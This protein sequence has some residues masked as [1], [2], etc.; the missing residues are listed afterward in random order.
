MNERI[1]AI[2]YGRVQMVMYRD[3]TERKASGLQ[4]TGE[5]QNLKDGTVKVIAEGTHEQLEKLIQ[6]LHKGS[7]LSNVEKVDV[8]WLQA[9]DLYSKFK[10]NYDR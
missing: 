6:K 1:E 5:V 8:Q 9:Q 7:V 2:V 3:F 4:L 10:I